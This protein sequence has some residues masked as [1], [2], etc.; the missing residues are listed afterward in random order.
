MTKKE[1]KANVF[2]FGCFYL[3]R[4]FAVSTSNMSKEKKKK[5]CLRNAVVVKKYGFVNSS[6]TLRL[7]FGAQIHLVRIVSQKGLN[8][9]VEN[10]VS[11]FT[12]CRLR[13]SR[14]NNQ[15]ENNNYRLY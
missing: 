11:F 8:S 7:E 10:K 12:C 13:G 1:K 15:A 2:I 9:F 5:C 6:S 3:T 4:S 14:L